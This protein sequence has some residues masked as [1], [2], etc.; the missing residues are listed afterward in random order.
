[1]IAEYARLKPTRLPLSQTMPLVLSKESTLEAM[2][3][4]PTIG[5][6]WIFEG[7]VLIYDGGEDVNHGEKFLYVYILYVLCLLRINN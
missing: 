3:K 5:N 1:M 4:Q 6:V 7:Q 2:R